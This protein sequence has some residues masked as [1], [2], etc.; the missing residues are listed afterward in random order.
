M[1]LTRREM[2]LASLGLLA[3]GCAEQTTRLTD[4]PRTEWPAPVSRPRGVAIP[5][6]P[7]PSRVASPLPRATTPEVTSPANSV[8]STSVAAALHALPRSSWA[9]KPPISARILPMNGVK[10]ITC[11]HEG[12]TPVW[13][14]DALTTRERME[15]IRASHI[16]RL[17]AGDIGYHFVIDRA[18]RLWEGRPLTFQGAHVKNHNENNIG[19]MMLGNFDKQSPTTAQLMTL[20]RT[21]GHLRR[22]YRVPLGRIYTHQELNP[23]ACPG[24]NLQ[25][26]IAS[27]RNNNML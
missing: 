6:E 7:A 27:M 18:G 4:R 23:T 1:K 22:Q 24:Q 14:N 21:L 10:S 5:V 13:F 16:Q 26:R 17:H 9:A 19:V 2:L 20:E 11:H 3:A 12:W 15:T 8:A 25:P